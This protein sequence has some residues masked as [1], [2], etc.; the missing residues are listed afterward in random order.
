MLKT[1]ILLMLCPFLMALKTEEPKVKDESAN[2]TAI[3]GIDS[4]IDGR[5]FV[6]KE[7]VIRLWGISVPE[8]TQSHFW[9]SKLLFETLLKQTSFSC[10]YKYKDTTGAAVMRCLSD[11]KD[12]AS[13]LVSMGVAQ[14]DESISG[15]LYKTEEEFAKENRYGIWKN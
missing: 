4:V 3:Y 5:T 6:V 11:G 9:A 2:V 15:G 12:I 14:D 13:M 8:E 10:Y 1:L 7:Q